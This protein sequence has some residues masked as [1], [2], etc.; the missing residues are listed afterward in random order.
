MKILIYA[1]L[2]PPSKGGLQY[3]NLE[4]AKGLFK[5]GHDIRLIT[6]FNEG[7]DKF[8][9]NFPFPIK[10]LPKWSFTPMA[11]L[12]SKGLPNWIIS[13][14]YFFIILRETRIFRPEVGFITDETANAFWGVI[15]DLAKIPYVSY[16]SV[17]L[18]EIKQIVPKYK[19]WIFIKIAILKQIRKWLWKSYKGAERILV[20]SNSTKNEIIKQAPELK[21]KVHVVPRSIDDR[22][23]ESPVDYE[24]VK[25]IKKSF[26][27]TMDQII[28]LSVSRL[29]K[30]KGIDDVLNALAMLDPL[31]LKK[32]K[33]FVIGNGRDREYLRELAKS[34]K[35]N[36]TVSFLGNIE[37]LN[38]ISYYDAC[39][40]FVLPSRRGVSESF[41]RV[42][43]EAAARSKASV[44]VNAGGMKDIIDDGN[45]G[46][47]ID[48]GDVEALAK[49][50]HFFLK[51]QEALIKM[52]REA[53][54][55][56]KEK[57]SRMTNAKIFENHLGN[58]ARA[59]K[60]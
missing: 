38:L 13:P 53:R 31:E 58:V 30:K 37:H 5:L 15:A 57:Y 55:R 39:D 11:S 41:G 56:V 33:Y 29:T 23:F 1:H 24:A 8:V 60:V 27:I 49:I 22:I 32:T 17:P 52:G 28:L 9:S 54:S 10:I 14:W 3:S 50:I 4:I 51:N 35:L 18:T 34:L 16:W 36:E 44:G 48:A 45:T 42:F 25:N 20:V 59:I 21:G 6:C 40:I 46:F 12:S 26:G 7:I 2:F 43:V 19:F 47:L